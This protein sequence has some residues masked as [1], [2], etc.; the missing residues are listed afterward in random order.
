MPPMFFEG[1]RVDE[2]VV[3]VYD[4]ELVEEIAEGIVHVVL[5]STR[6]ITQP[7][8]HDCVLK[9]PISATERRLP[10]FSRCHAQAVISIPNIEFREIF[11]TRN[12]VEKFADKR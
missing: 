11:G 10:F 4:E 2:E 9:Q 6:G 5:K 3:Q 8:G 7:K 12:T 1:I